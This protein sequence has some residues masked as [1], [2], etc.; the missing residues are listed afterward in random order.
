MGPTS[1]NHS[2]FYVD[3]SNSF[4]L[5]WELHYA[6]AQTPRVRPIQAFPVGCQLF[7]ARIVIAAGDVVN[8]R[9]YD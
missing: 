1:V 5:L 8:V 6:R 4:P 2:L 3:A 7:A 9:V